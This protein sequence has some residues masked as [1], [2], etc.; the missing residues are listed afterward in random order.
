MENGSAVLH[1]ICTSQGHLAKQ[2]RLGH[3]HRPQPIYPQTLGL[4]V[5]SAM[6]MNFLVV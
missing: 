1:A 2:H 5:Y 3:M 4:V 6:V